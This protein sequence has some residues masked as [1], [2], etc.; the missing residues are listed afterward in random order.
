MVME[1][2]LMIGKLALST[3]YEPSIVGNILPGL[4]H[5]LFRTTLEEELLLFL[6]KNCDEE[7]VASINRLLKNNQG[8]LS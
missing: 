8:R 5:S 2:S 1:G 7:I 6:F 4:F 3:Y